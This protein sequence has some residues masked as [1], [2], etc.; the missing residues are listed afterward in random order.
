MLSSLT[1]RFPPQNDLNIQG[2]LTKKKEFAN[3]TLPKDVERI[4]TRGD[5]FLH[6]KMSVLFFHRYNYLLVYKETGV[7]KTG[8]G[9]ANGE[10]MRISSSLSPAMAYL[11]GKCN[12]IEKF[13]ILTPG[14][15][16]E[17]AWTS[18]YEKHSSLSKIP[19]FYVLDHY[20]RFY[21]FYSGYDSSEL[22]RLFDNSFFWMDEIQD[23]LV[24]SKEKEEDRRMYNWFRWLFSILSNIKL[25]F[26]SATPLI[27]SPV[28]LSYIVNLIP[29]DV[30][31]MPVP[32]EKED[33]ITIA[34]LYNNKSD[35]QLERD[36]K[37]YLTGIIS[38]LKNKQ[39]TSIKV[40]PKES[41]PIM[42]NGVYSGMNV[43][44][45]KMAEPQ[46]RAYR[47][48]I[49]KRDVAHNAGL[50]T[51]L[52]G[53][54]IDVKKNKT[55]R[56]TQKIIEDYGCKILKL[57]E[58]IESR[59]GVIF[60]VSR[61]VKSG[62]E[63]I[64]KYI[65]DV[66]GFKSLTSKGQPKFPATKANRYMVIGSNNANT[67]AL[68]IINDPR[69]VDGEY[70]KIIITSI[71]GSTA[72]SLHHAL[73]YVAMDPA[74]HISDEK[75][76]LGR[77]DRP[78]SYTVY[79]R[80]YGK[81]AEVMMYYLDADPGSKVY[82]VDLDM[83]TQNII[84]DKPLDQIRTIM[85]R[86]AYDAQLTYNRNQLN[87]LEGNCE[88]GF[89]NEK[90]KS[91]SDLSTYYLNHSKE[92]VEDVL[93]EFIAAIVLE[94]SIDVD[95]FWKRKPRNVDILPFYRTLARL[96]NQGGR[97]NTNLGDFVYVKR[98]KN[99]LFVQNAI[100]RGK[101]YPAPSTS[102]YAL[103]HATLEKDS[104]TVR[105]I[106]KV[107]SV[108]KS[109]IKS[110]IRLV[111][112]VSYS[113]VVELEAFLNTKCTNENKTLIHD[114]ITVIQ[115][116]LINK[117][118]IELYNYIMKRYLGN[119]VF[120]IRKPITAITILSNA[121]TAKDM[122]NIAKSMKNMEI[123]QNGPL[124]L[125]H[126]FG[127][128]RDRIRGT[129]YN[130]FTDYIY[131]KKITVYDESRHEF[132]QLDVNSAESL[133]YSATISKIT[134]N[135]LKDFSDKMYEQYAEKGYIWGAKFDPEMEF[136]IYDNLKVMIAP[137]KTKVGKVNMIKAPRTKK[138]K[139]Y[140]NYEY[141]AYL[142]FFEI[143]DRAYTNGEAKSILD[144][145][146]RGKQP[147]TGIEWLNAL[148]R[149][150]E[151]FILSNPNQDKLFKPFNAIKKGWETYMTDYPSTTMGEQLFIL[152][153][154]NTSIYKN[155]IQITTSHH[156]ILEQ[157]MESSGRLNVF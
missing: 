96:V 89:T 134:S 63:I 131:A 87:C 118:P 140:G 24:R 69:N 67:K 82:D 51:A 23:F 105:S 52:F 29:R 92:V 142:A 16:V 48:V 38:H 127:A 77:I 64:E 33:D 60:I 27:M 125:V 44:K 153:I 156:E 132:I 4:A 12:Y 74:S 6:Q 103:T 66:L 42:I 133:A 147:T 43:V 114:K 55:T 93:N 78:E 135:K 65:S 124:T 84:K 73:T 47:E 83:H 79:N 46:L 102:I 54:K 120:E 19:P 75:Q 85:Q 71:V 41:V 101:D 10:E 81:L 36:L 107:K 145:H 146:M 57:K 34:K 111:D 138:Y 53:L 5:L 95:E 128:Q 80:K 112:K 26:A 150:I 61:W 32:Q 15:V 154:L 151:T 122:K 62:T 98:I 3:L 68:S 152:F 141:W 8:E 31:P 149:V 100:N 18:T 143:G 129:A 94:L 144:Q 123:E 28:E 45:C 13:V 117:N 39:Q 49:K 116:I 155:N 50:Q 72:I 20:I 76:R 90:V 2:L 109:A 70:V 22:K 121:S 37:P 106:D 130:I 113:S 97:I 157:Y 136:R 119:Y 56:I 17:S 137:T 115:N 35:K 30:P 139:S 104:P 11:T 14:D 99:V 148:E 108:D 9:W 91:G 21:N 88:Y 1:Y 86:V 7:G 25:A 58:I 59:P 40:W 110:S 126:I